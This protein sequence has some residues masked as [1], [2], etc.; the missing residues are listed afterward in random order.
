MVECQEARI[1]EGFLAVI[2]VDGRSIA[3]AGRFVVRIWVVYRRKRRA[4]TP[5]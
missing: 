2:F 4:R 3:A 1:E 5:G